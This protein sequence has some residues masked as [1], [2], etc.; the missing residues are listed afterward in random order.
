MLSKL[1]VTAVCEQVTNR[2]WSGVVMQL[3]TGSG[4]PVVRDEEFECCSWL[5][6]IVWI[7]S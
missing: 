2:S 1:G 3:L 4:G 5:G 7:P 6:K